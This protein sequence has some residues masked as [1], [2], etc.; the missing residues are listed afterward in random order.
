MC[1]VVGV[2]CVVCVC[3]V[4][5]CCVVCVFVFVVCFV[6]WCVLLFLMF[7]QSRTNQT[8]KWRP[9]ASLDKKHQTQNKYNNNQIQTT[10]VVFHVVCLFV[11]SVF[12]DLCCV[13]DVV[14]VCVVSV[15]VCV[16]V[17]FVVCLLCVCCCCVALRCWLLCACTLCDVVSVVVY[18]CSIPNKP[19][20]QAA[21]RGAT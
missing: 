1:V 3:C 11:L 21:A 13:V 7:T 17:V 6:V 12:G 15:C 8:I 20:N 4:C 10:F 19:N 2:V 14:C 5:C 16:F 9:R 18:V